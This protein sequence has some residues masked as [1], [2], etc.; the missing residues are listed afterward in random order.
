MSMVFSGYVKRELLTT[1]DFIHVR[2]P[3]TKNP[4]GTSHS[5]DIFVST[6]QAMTM[7]SHTWSTVIDHCS[8]AIEL[9]LARI[10]PDFTWLTPLS[11]IF[12]NV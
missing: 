11:N 8:W 10:S 12:L 3:K 4:S 6:Q 5:N 7:N 2:L 9:S 1:G